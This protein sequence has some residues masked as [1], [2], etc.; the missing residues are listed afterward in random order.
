MSPALPAMVLAMLLALSFAVCGRAAAASAAPAE[1]IVAVAVP[2]AGQDADKGAEIK[3]TVE[4]AVARLDTGGGIAG[5]PV[6]LVV[7]DDGCSATGGAAAATRIVALHPALV[8][9]HP[10]AAAAVAAAKV[11]GAAGVLFIAT[12]TRHPALTQRRAGKTIFRLDARDDRQGAFA[13]RYLVAAYPGQ[14]IALIS[15]RTGYARRIVADARATLVAAT[16]PEPVLLTLVAGEKDYGRLVADIARSGAGAVLFAGFPMEAAIVLRQMRAA[17]LDAAFVASDAVATRE[18]VDMADKTA[19]DVHFIQPA[20][21]IA[22]GSHDA[23]SPSNSLASSPLAMR[24]Q[25]AVDAWVQAARSAAGTTAATVAAALQA[26][27]APQGNGPLFDA[28][29]DAPWLAGFR[30]VGA[31]DIGPTP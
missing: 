18:F 20:E 21:A 24:T 26:A 19:G 5:G 15:D 17:G 9:G 6:R 4:R 13:A 29:G 23:V 12:A 16:G 25:R 2:A 10:C 11:Y 8:L 27:P 22:S 31:A 1:L 14:R 3:A 30:V 7:E 28:Q